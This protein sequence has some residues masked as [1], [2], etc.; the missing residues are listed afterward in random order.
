[1]QRL[2]EWRCRSELQERMSSSC[3]RSDTSGITEKLDAT[4]V[5]TASSQRDS[6]EDVS[7]LLRDHDV[8]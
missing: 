2:S 8:A 6:V 5:G 4:P 3:S 7:I 1:M